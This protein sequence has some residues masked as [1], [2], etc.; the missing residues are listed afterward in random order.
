[1]EFTSFKPPTP[2]TC[3][4]TF[5]S[6]AKAAVMPHGRSPGTTSSTT[7]ARVLVYSAVNQ[8]AQLQTKLHE[9]H[10]RLFDDMVFDEPR[11]RG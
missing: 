9:Q 4:S 3:S 7:S 10:A 6:P 8:A 5:S 2:A 1:M 11:C